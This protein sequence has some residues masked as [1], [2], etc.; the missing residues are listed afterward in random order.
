M[1]DAQTSSEP[2]LERNVEKTGGQ[3]PE[4]QS[5]RAIA[6]L[7]VLGYHLWT[8]RLPG[9]FVGVDVFFVI[10]GFLITGQ[11]LRE[12]D[13][14]GRIGLLEF[15]ARRIR[16]L[17]PAAFVVLAVTIGAVL[18]V[19]PKEMWRTSLIETAASALY[20]ENWASVARH[21][22]LLPWVDY[23][24]PVEHFWSL[25]V[26]E[27]FYLLWP[28][29]ILAGLGVAAWVARLRGAKAWG[30]LQVVF[31]MLLAAFA[32]AFVYSLW[33]TSQ[34]PVHATRN[35]LS[36]A[37]EFA[38]GGMLAFA[39]RLG[40]LGLS[41]RVRGAIHMAASWIGLVLIVFAATLPEELGLHPAPLA[42]LPVAG[43]TLWIWAESSPSWLSPSRY[44]A[45]PPVQFVG[46][47]SYGVYLWHQPIY[48]LV[49]LGTGENV[50]SFGALAVVGGSILL[51]WLSKR[52]IEDPFRTS[53]FWKPLGR[54]YVFA[55]VGMLAIV[56]LC[57]AGIA[58]GGV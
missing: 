12:V 31:V 24:L 14:T 18:L 46:D 37:W 8:S 47:V 20:V 56:A 41:Q 3:R 26:E 25:S 32:L 15:W 55:A 49:L 48:I 58:M 21:L 13:R 11:L 10:S 23:G 42:V 54:T 17:L 5:L 52:Y 39:P 30:R 34:H 2:R 36:A 4:I 29:L 43:A 6:I 38:V 57:A 40:D 9:G 51:G 27:Q 44:G 35:T 45:L 19:L 1:S 28:L 53:P 22:G 50:R 7:L 16:R 33:L